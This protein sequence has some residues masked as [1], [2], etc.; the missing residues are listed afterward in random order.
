MVFCPKRQPVIVSPISSLA[1]SRLRAKLHGKTPLLPSR[2]LLLILAGLSLG[3][4]AGCRVFVDGLGAW[5]GAVPDERA[6]TSAL[7]LRSDLWRPNTGWSPLH[8]LPEVPISNADAP[9][10]RWSHPK[11]SAALSAAENSGLISA[12]A[13]RTA[14]NSAGGPRPALGE[15]SVNAWF[16]SL[17]HQNDLSGWNAAILW[18]HYDP[19][20]AREAVDVLARLV[21][22]PPRLFGRRKTIR[23]PRPRESQRKDKAERQ[24]QARPTI[25]RG[26]RWPSS[27]RICNVLPPRP[28]VSSWEPSLM[29]PKRRLVRRGWPC[30]PESSRRR[31]KTS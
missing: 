24:I 5:R 3:A 2:L 6:E 18:S 14:E 10:E 27:R 16:A 15:P 30:S 9:L 20:A 13:R 11:F 29:I 23:R 17:A 22:H 7:A 25:I 28:G 31:S 12:S 8:L 19:I 4:G 21:R 1:I 26:R